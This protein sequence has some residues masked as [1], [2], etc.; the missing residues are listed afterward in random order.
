M[1]LFET[2]LKVLFEPDAPVH[3]YL[4]GLGGTG[5][6]LAL[7]LARTVYHARQTGKEVSL[8]FIDHDIVEP[9]NVGR[10]YFEPAQVGMNKAEALAEWISIA[11]GLDVVAYPGRLESFR[12]AGGLSEQGIDLL[13]GCVD[14]YKARR[15][16][17]QVAVINAGMWWLD[18]GNERIDGQ[19]LIGRHCKENDF[20]VSAALGIAAR[21]PLPSLQHPELLEPPAEE[22]VV[23][24]LSCADLTVLEEQGLHVNQLMAA[25]A[26]QYVYDIIIRR[27][28]RTFATYLSLDPIFARSNEITETNLARFRPEALCPA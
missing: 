8:V 21:L 12:L 15:E 11:W 4:V 3:I 20:G 5:S 7:S 22:E 1:S 27:E 13:I 9:K 10:Q 23:D 28:L 24:D 2:R 18:C 25:A 16:L 14:N 17:Q 26:A 19:V 6:A